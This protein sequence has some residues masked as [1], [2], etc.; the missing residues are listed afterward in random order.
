MGHNASHWK[1]VVSDDLAL[2][3][4]G[5]ECST[6]WIANLS[7]PQTFLKDLDNSYPTQWEWPEI[8]LGQGLLGRCRR[9]PN[10]VDQCCDPRLATGYERARYSG[11]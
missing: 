3:V 4:G 8:G 2:L 5:G 7:D 1:A 11:P 10:L 9:K 6:A